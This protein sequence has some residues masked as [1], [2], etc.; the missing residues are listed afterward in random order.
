MKKVD[1][2]NFFIIYKM[3]ETTYCQKNKDITLNRAKEYYKMQEI[4]TEIY[5][6]KKKRKQE[7]IEKIDIILCLKKRNKKLK[8]Y[9]KNYREANKRR[10]S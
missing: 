2:Y 8:E 7:N 5:L 1:H 3:T 10:R 9:Q 4:D 6:K